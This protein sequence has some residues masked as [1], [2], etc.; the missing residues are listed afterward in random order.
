MSIGFGQILLVLVIILVLFGA[1]KLPKVMAEL[2][3]GLKSFKKGL[4][5]EEKQIAPNPKKSSKKKASS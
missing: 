4:N 1:G 5:E 2:A 3:Q